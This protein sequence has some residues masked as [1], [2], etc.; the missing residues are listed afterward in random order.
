[1]KK[2]LIIDDEPDILK[3]VIFRI[4]NLGYE[5]ITGTDGQQ[6]VDLAKF[7]IPDLILLDFRLP[8]MNGME[9]C[10][11]IR[12]IEELKNTPVILF[13]ASIENPEE[14]I[15]KCKANDFL[16]KPFEP[17]ILINKIESFLKN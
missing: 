15:K 13:T 2:I 3:I 1:M 14:K 7:H 10:I 5:I 16:S 17:E 4:K 11:K 12:E 9:A 8:K 6:A